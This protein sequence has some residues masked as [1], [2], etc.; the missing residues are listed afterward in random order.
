MFD[1]VMISN[2]HSSIRQFQVKRFNSEDF[3][4]L[5]R[6]LNELLPSD[7]QRERGDL[8]DSHGLTWP[9]LDIDINK[10]LQKQEENSQID[11]T[12]ADRDL[13]ED[14]LERVSGLSSLNFPK[15]EEISRLFQQIWSTS[16]G[17]YIYIEGEKEA[18][19]A[20]IAG[21]YRAKGIIRATRFSPAS[22]I[23]KYPRYWEAIKDRVLGRN[24]YKPLEKY[25]RIIA[26][27]ECEKIQDIEEFFDCFLGKDFNIYLTSS[28]HDYEL[29]I[30]DENEVFI[31]FFAPEEDVIGSTLYLLGREIASKFAAIF[32][33]RLRGPH[34]SINAI[35]LEYMRENDVQPKLKEVRDRFSNCR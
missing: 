20:L 1:D 22:I 30:I 18:F 8:R 27:N 3:Y 26:V 24:D 13:L 23:N 15:I 28:Y 29:V 14:I 5:L 35:S 25:D 9:T 34:H 19:E 33:N 11:V 4:S 10:A 12:K 7:L 32:D 2:I 17:N 31:L 16:E 21:T 6:D